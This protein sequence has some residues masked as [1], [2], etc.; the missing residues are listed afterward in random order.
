[1]TGPPDM[2]FRSLEGKTILQDAE[3][4]FN[5]QIPFDLRE[6]LVEIQKVLDA[7]YAQGYAEGME[8]AVSLGTRG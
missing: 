1:M 3:E 7:A 4:Y 2:T 8:A 6:H 5:G